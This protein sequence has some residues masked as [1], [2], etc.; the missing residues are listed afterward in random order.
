MFLAGLWG[1]TSSRIVYSWVTPEVSQQHF[2]RIMVVGLSKESDH[3]LQQKMEQHLVADLKA[4]GYDAVSALA[5]W[6]PKAFEKMDEAQVLNQLQHS[7]ADAVMTIVLLDKSQ[8]R[9]YIP[10]RII[11]SPYG[12]YHNRFY[13]Y[14]MTVYDRIYSPGYYGES[15]RYFWES[16]FY[17]VATKKLL[18]SSQTESFDPSSVESM[19]HQ[20]G[21]LIVDD[22]ISKQ[23]FG[24]KH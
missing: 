24:P 12:I 1:C 21:Q 15:T 14:Y 16:N 2:S 18:Y 7:G 8:E 23:L 19:G 22:M 17:D 20:Y 6:G 4:K 10:G 3:E 9:Y 11:Y 5:E 13:G